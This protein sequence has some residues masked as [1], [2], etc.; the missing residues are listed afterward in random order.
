MWVY[1]SEGEFRLQFKQLEQSFHGQTMVRSDSLENSSERA[2]LD[3]MVVGN[4]FVVLTVPL[5]RQP[6]MRTLLPGHFVAKNAERL[7]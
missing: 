4:Y 7:S 1:R 3:W 6:Y 5:G 2:S